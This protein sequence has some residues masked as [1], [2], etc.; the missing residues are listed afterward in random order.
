[1]RE[2]RFASVRCGVLTALGLLQACGSQADGGGASEVASNL[3]P[4]AAPSQEEGEAQQALCSAMV[5]SNASANSCWESPRYAWDGARCESLYC[6][7][8][9]S[10]CDILFGSATD[11]YGE[12]G[13]CDP[14]ASER[15][16]CIARYPN[17]DT[18]SGVPHESVCL[19]DGG[20]GCDSSSFLSQAAAVCIAELEGM[21]QGLTPWTANL[22][23]NNGHRRVIWSVMN[24][25]AQRAD[26]GSGGAL[27]MLDAT[28]GFVLESGGWEAIP[29]RP[30][31][32]DRAP[33]TAEAVGRSDYSLSAGVCLDGMPRELCAALADTWTRIGLLEHASVAAFA[34]FSLQLLGL[35][36]PPELLSLCQQAMQDE[37][38]HTRI[39][40]GLA[41][42]YA[43]EPLGPG[44]L[45]LDGAL[46]DPSEDLLAHVAMTT[47]L[48]GC[49]GETVAAL[50]AREGATCATDPHVRQVLS[51]IAADEERHAE[52]AWRFLD[53]A[54]AQRPSLAPALLAT[55]RAQLAGNRSR[56][57][58]ATSAETG[59]LEHGILPLAQ[60]R[61]LEVQALERVILPCLVALAGKHA[62]LPASSAEPRTASFS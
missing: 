18:D 54:L 40:F 5:A 19:A 56:I 27:L 58:G 23:Y 28:T 8:T 34:R 10:D 59:L 35:G 49:I 11:C 48:E 6:A 36:A 30:F 16:A 21:A 37:L 14:L 60:H 3:T 44:P 52:L 29:G 24:T 7:C 26:G 4:G 32:I 12:R 17:Q 15:A 57:N 31:L 25:M 55:A 13:A 22:V 39:A 47:L 38:R 42:A 46:D 62:P 61:E 2:H 43:D 53:W 33:R 45:N 1:M 9:G 20:T 50:G 51:E 41:S